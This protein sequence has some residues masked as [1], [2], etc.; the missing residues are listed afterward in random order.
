MTTRS[1]SCTLSIMEQK[2]KNP[3]AVALGKIGGQKVAERGPEYYAE[4]QAKRK[5]RK[6]GRPRNPPKATHKGVLHVAD[7]ELPCFVLEDGR[8]VITGRGLTQAIG[9]KGRGQGVARI[10]GLLR[11]KSSNNSSLSLAIE[12]PLIFNSGGPVPAQGYDAEV[13]VHLCEAILDARDAGVLKTPQEQ[14]YGDACYILTRAF[15]K[16]GLIA[17]IDEATG[18]Q[19]VRDKQVLQALLDRF[20]RKELAAWAKR[21]PDEFYREMFRLKGWEWK[22]MKV[23]RPQVVGHYTRDLVYERLAPGIVKELEERNPRDPRGRRKVKHH[24]W[25]TED[26][27]SPALAQHLHAVIGFMRASDSWKQFYKMIQRAYPK[28]GENFF[29]PLSEGK[30]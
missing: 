15:A 20:L 10:A 23:N 12:S 16:V 5:Q 21:F 27:G 24:Q 9:M 19:E 18:Y 30:A 22:G 28:K 3:H 11:K 29:L 13:L 8:R 25:L 2:D 4:I 26:I 17:L 6:G 14:R 7:I 1:E